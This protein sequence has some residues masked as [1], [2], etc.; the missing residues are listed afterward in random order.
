MPPR[1]GACARPCGWGRRRF[2]SR[3]NVNKHVDGGQ[4]FVAR[5]SPHPNTNNATWLQNVAVELRN[6]AG[7]FLGGW[8]AAY[9]GTV[10]QEGQANP[11]SSHGSEHHQRTTTHSAKHSHKIALKT[12]PSVSSGSD[13]GLGEP[14]LLPSVEQALL[15][16]GNVED[17]LYFEP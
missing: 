5:G 3:G 1:A 15:L 16:R 2:R 9:P 13:K 10:A 6:N 11:G 4:T 7:G 8:H 12:D 14:Y 17:V